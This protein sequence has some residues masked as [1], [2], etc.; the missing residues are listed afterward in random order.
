MKNEMKDF[1]ENVTVEELKMS[2]EAKANFEDKNFEDKNFED[3]LLDARLLE[4]RRVFEAA[5]EGYKFFVENQA[6]AIGLFFTVMPD[7]VCLA[8]ALDSIDKFAVEDICKFID[9]DC[10]NLTHTQALA[11]LAAQIAF[12][13]G[14]INISVNGWAAFLKVAVTFD[15]GTLKELLKTMPSDL[16]NKF[17]PIFGAFTLR[18]KDD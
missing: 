15:N 12:K 13:D 14:D 8:M 6:A 9:G 17:F 16:Y 7:D 4:I 10:R 11:K 1:I 5:G 3:K 2:S 18:T